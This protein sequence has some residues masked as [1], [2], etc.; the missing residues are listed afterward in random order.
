MSWIEKLQETGKAKTRKRKGA[1]PAGP[2]PVVHEIIV[3]V[4]ASDPA[5]GFP[6]E[7]AI[8]HYTVVD[9]LLTM[10]D[11]HGR[12]GDK[13]ETAI[14]TDGNPRVVAARLVKKR[15]AE[16]RETNFDGPLNYPPLCGV[17]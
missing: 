17:V 2:P 1:V 12:A 9:N 10:T 7:A 8:G 5:T 6:G 13:P 11:E 14:V 16:K 3:S 15:W 4:R